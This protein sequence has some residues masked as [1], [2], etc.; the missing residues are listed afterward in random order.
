MVLWFSAGLSLI[1]QEIINIRPSVTNL[2]GYQPRMIRL[3]I[4]IMNYRGPADT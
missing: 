3:I 2:I 4:T 1:G